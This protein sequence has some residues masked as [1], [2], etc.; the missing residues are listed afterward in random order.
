M[1]DTRN[2]KPEILLSLKVG[3]KGQKFQYMKFIQQRTLIKRWQVAYLQQRPAI[4]KGK[5]TASKTK[6]S[7]TNLVEIPTIVRDFR[8]LTVASSAK[9][10]STR[11][12]I[13]TLGNDMI[14]NI[15]RSYLYISLR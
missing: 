1:T 3:G 7:A 5:N 12:A 9:V 13:A 15:I 8:F 11:Q 2:H 10:S 4:T 14:G 6:I